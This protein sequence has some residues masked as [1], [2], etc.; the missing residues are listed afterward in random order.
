[1]NID[2]VILA[3]GNS[4]R[5][6]SNLPKF[7]LEIA[8]KPMISHI[9]EQYKL[10]D[11]SNIYVVTPP[12]YSSC[13][14]LSDVNVVVQPVPNGNAS[15]LLLTLPYLNSEYTIVQY[16]D[17]PLITH[18]DIS[19]L[20]T[21][22][23]NDLVFIAGIL[24]NDLISKPYGRVFLD[25][26]NNFDKLIEYRDLTIEQRN[27]KLFNTGF[28]MFKTSILK[29]YLDKVPYHQGVQE[30]YITDIFGILKNNNKLIK[31]VIASNYQNFHGVNTQEE[32][33]VANNIMMNRLKI[34]Y[35]SYYNN[36]I[37]MEHKSCKIV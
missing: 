33:K 35:N 5:M 29:Q 3:G 26:N 9:I 14:I 23:G 8:N 28:Y 10:L 21:N 37:N 20:C 11:F 7:L 25:K 18:E 36:E 17:M 6:S 15:A 22:T 12:K 19:N 1:M 34:Y 24:P 13:P 27:Q 4:S 31:V 2:I 16:A 30:R 32:L